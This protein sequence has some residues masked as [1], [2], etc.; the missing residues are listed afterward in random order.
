MV[1]NRQ[2][3]LLISFLLTITTTLTLTYVEASSESNI[4]SRFQQYLQTRTD[5][6]TPN[7]TQSTN[8]LTTQ[9][10][11]LSLQ[12]QTIEFVSGKPLILLKW[13]GTNP[14]LPS[15]MLYSH[16]DVVPAEHDKWDHHPF[17]AR[18]DDEGRIYARGSQDM[19][20][21]GMQYLEA[22]RNLKGWDFQPKR[23][24]YLVYAPDEEVGGHDGAE[25]FSLSKVFPE[26]NV[27]VVLDEGT[28]NIVSYLYLFN[29]KKCSV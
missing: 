10:N 18:V 5:H 15:I 4:I 28:L 11:S 19:K 25:K 12:S 22:V 3:I 23:T 17:K 16:T 29:S 21:V 27:G 13:T 2:N 26:L 20:C 6:P 7:Y 8:F 9:A 24:V 1:F 14:N